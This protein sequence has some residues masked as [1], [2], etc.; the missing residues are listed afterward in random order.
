MN[1][2]QPGDILLLC[3][4]RRM[5]KDTFCEKMRQNDLKNY[6]ITGDQPFPSNALKVN[7]IAFADSLKK[8]VA[9]ILH[10]SVEELELRKDMSLD[11]PYNFKMGQPDNPTFRH[12][13]IDVAMHVR[14]TEPDHWTHVAIH[15]SYSAEDLNVVTDHRFPNEVEVLRKMFPGKVYVARIRRDGVEIPPLTDVSEHSLDDC[16]V[17]WS[18]FGLHNP[19]IASSS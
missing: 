18:I 6:A 19:D 17:D 8:E 13:L 16:E 12:V 5:G 14:E 1:S 4:Y 9:E 2:F 3:G 7:R 15:N 11:R 10:M